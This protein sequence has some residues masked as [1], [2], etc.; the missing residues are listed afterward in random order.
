[1]KDG[2][3]IL[4]GARTPFGSYMGSLRSLSATELGAI[5]AKEALRRSG[6]DGALVGQVV[7]GNVLQTSADASFIARHVELKAGLPF[8]TSALTVNRN[9]GSGLEAVLTGAK[10]ILAEETECILAGGAENM[11]QAPYVLRG[12]REG[13]GLGKGQM[14]DYLWQS[15]TDS[16]NGLIMGLTAENLA[17][18]YRISREEQD[19]FALRSHQ[20]A[21]EARNTG[22]LAREII[23]VELKSKKGSTIVEQD[24]HIRP[25]VS[26]EKLGSL[27]PAFREGGSVTAGNASGINDGAAALVIC[28]EKLAER[29]GLRPLGRLVT[30]ATAGVDPDIM[31]IGPAPAIRRALERAGLKL[32]D[33]DLIEVNEAFAA[34]YLAVEK[35]LG[36]ERSKAN[37]NGGAIALGHPLGASGAR[38]LISLLYELRDRELRYGVASLCIGGGQG[39]A[40]IVENLQR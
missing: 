26:L 40:A 17:E 6:V 38:I 22:R 23:S 36:F 32:E 29:E 24:E 18:K 1:M 10:T 25:D 7:F 20:C 21:A 34:Q 27:R 9:C 16:Y 4:E 39:I 8:E 19:L 3:V 2:I 13:W 33:L 30:W 14:E 12:A 5:A 31:G 35:E 37:V 15:L 11:S 28:T